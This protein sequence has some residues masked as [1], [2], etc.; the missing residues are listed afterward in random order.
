MPG[1][2][3]QRLLDEAPSRSSVAKLP[4][5][6]AAGSP[7]ATSP[8]V[9]AA[10]PPTPSPTSSPPKPTEVARNSEGDARRGGASPGGGA[11]GGAGAGAG[12]APA[13]PSTTATRVAGALLGA[14]RRRG[15]MPRNALVPST[16]R[17][18]HGRAGD[19]TPVKRIGG[20]YGV[21]VSKP[22]RTPARFRSGRKLNLFGRRVVRRTRSHGTNDATATA[23]ASSKKG[24]SKRQKTNAATSIQ[25]SG[26]T[27]S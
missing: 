24:P 21:K 25:R 27:L 23:A 16:T 4:A 5:R 14:N 22:S 18:P 13:A 8:A 7:Q 3:L 10:T 2:L 15:P 19:P 20:G 17:S 6:A 26:S 1:Q 9:Q 11:G 12:G